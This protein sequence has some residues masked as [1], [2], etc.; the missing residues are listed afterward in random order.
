MMSISGKKNVVVLLLAILVFSAAT[1]VFAED[2]SADMVSRVKGQIMEGKIYISE[3]KCRIDTPQSVVISRVDRNVAWML[4]PDQK[5]Y[6]E[7]PL[8]NQA[9]SMVVG[10]DKV[11]G[12]L[13]RE[14]LGREVLN[15]VS[16]EK[17]RI[18]YK[19]GSV[20]QTVLTWI[21]ENSN[22]PLKT[23]AEDGSWDVEYRNISAVSLSASF[24]EIPAG[25]RKMEMNIP[26]LSDM[27]NTLKTQ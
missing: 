25:Y 6:M 26:A 19:L 2:F 10:K 14:S 7:M 11:P 9:D 21:P 27:G 1:V 23:A 18:V 12:E 24:F 22:F 5:M 4:M 13:K 16:V 8:Q 20:E 17:Y 15:G 3:G